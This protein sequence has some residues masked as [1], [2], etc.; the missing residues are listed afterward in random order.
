VDAKTISIIGGGNMGRSLVGGLVGDRWAAEQIWVS[1]ADNSR[2]QNLQQQFSVRTS[3]SNIETAEHADIL[4]LAVKP[5][6]IKSVALEISSTVRECRPLVISIAAGVRLADLCCWLG[7]KVAIVRAMPN[8]PALVKSAAT[9][10]TA[11]EA[12]TA[13]QCNDAESVLR[14]VGLTLWLTDETL[15]DAVT[16]LSGSG[17]AYF[18][19]VMEAMEN[20]AQDLGLDKDSARLLT[21]QTAFGAAK[22]AL[23]SSYDSA[24]LRAHVTSPG[25]TTEKAIEV[26]RDRHLDDIF[27]DAM[28]AAYQRSNELAELLAKS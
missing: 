13:D 10:L 17:P 27:K 2:L 28:R 11:N 20:A 8:T 24:T 16:A 18:F 26:M 22:M 21:L 3:Q 5:Q 7:D 12:A 15:M 1:D 14:S 19:L 23:E 6:I 9:A 4:V 25:G